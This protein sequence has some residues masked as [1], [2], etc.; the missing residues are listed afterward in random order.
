M[1]WHINLVHYIFTLLFFKKKIKNNEQSP[2][3]PSNSGLH[4]HPQVKP[5]HFREE[6][7]FPK[8]F[9]ASL[10]LSWDKDLSFLIP[11]KPSFPTPRCADFCSAIGSYILR[12]SSISLWRQYLMIFGRNDYSSAF[13]LQLPQWLLF[14]AFLSSMQKFVTE[15]QNPFPCTINNLFFIEKYTFWV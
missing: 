3:V 14:N 2:K 5:A 7:N 8:D 13:L 10:W 9:S 12:S 11:S 6:Y 15:M 1:N 4:C